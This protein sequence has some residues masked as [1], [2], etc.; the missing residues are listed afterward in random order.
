MAGFSRVRQLVADGALHNLKRELKKFL[1][2]I[3]RSSYDEFF[4]VFQS[5]G[6]Y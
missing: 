1:V 6:K 5:K 4:S 3:S 2:F